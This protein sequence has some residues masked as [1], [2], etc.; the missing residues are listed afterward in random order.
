MR[1]TTRASGPEE[2]GSD[3][4]K[5]VRAVERRFGLR[6]H[7]GFHTVLAERAF[8]LLGQHGAT[9]L[10][11]VIRA[12]RD[13]DDDDALVVAMG[14]AASIGETYFFRSP[15]QLRAFEQLVVQH[16]YAK[17]A[18]SSSRVLRFWSAACAT[19]EEPYTLAMMFHR[20]LPDFR[21]QI[22]ASDMNS[23]ALEVAREGV[24][25][26]R[27]FRGVDPK[28][29]PFLTQ[30]GD[31]WVVDK[32]AR[33]KVTFLELNLVLDRLPD[34]LRQ[35]HN[36]DAILCRNVL[37]YI[38]ANEIPGVMKKLSACAGQRAVVALTPAE[39]N[40]GRHLDGFETGPEGIWVR[41]DERPAAAA[42]DTKPERRALTPRPPPAPL[43]PAPLTPLTP[44]PSTSGGDAL[45]AQAVEA[46]RLARVAADKAELSEALRLAEIAS[47][48]QPAA[49][50]PF[51]LIAMVSAAAGQK[52]R[53]IREFERALFLDRSFV[54]AE[55]GLG[56]L[57]AKEGRSDD[58]HKHLSRAQKLLSRKSPDEVV[59]GL[60]LPVALALRLVE[61]AL[62]PQGGAS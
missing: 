2:P 51:Y 53:A 35:L 21:V 15:N 1:G 56:E 24:Y 6:L 60:G 23:A 39:T 42:A 4:T 14:R 47:G 38:D 49:A 8:K 17:R 19:G 50:E 18:R 9:T 40:A 11:D 32:E 10:A 37:I 28:T 22:V 43:T 7:V 57:L 20:A 5:L 30:R 46:L 27:S 52:D 48:L 31:A 3:V 16:A 55:L 59:P 36:F 61:G 54:A 25:R 33:L 12:L 58:A 44:P 62:G 45:G 29:L 34:P 41:T 13:G 26:K